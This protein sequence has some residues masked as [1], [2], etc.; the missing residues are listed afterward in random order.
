MQIHELTLLSA[1]DDD[2]NVLAI[3]T[4]SRTYKITYANLAKAIIESYDGSSLYGS[5]QTIKQAFTAARTATSTVT[6]TL[7]TAINACA[8]TYVSTDNITQLSDI[9]V[10]S[11]GR[12][13]LSNAQSPNGSSLVFSFFCF[14][15]SSRA[16]LIVARPDSGDI[17]VNYKVNSTWSGWSTELSASKATV[18]PTIYSP[19]T[20][21]AW[22]TQ[23]NCWYYKI[24]TRVH[25]H[26]AVEGLTANTNSTIVNLPSGYI[27]YSVNI[28]GARGASASNHATIWVNSSGTVSA[29]S[30]DTSVA[31]D[32]EFDAFG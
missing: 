23:G 15:N 25:V 28:V 17:W 18:T 10:N 8:Q 9:P 1:P 31:G 11:M 19:S 24:G 7:T 20:G 6:S 26:V 2:A 27:P 32:L 5:S 13:L 21:T 12:V 29:R 16:C 14:G 22:S 4:G 30:T 3:D